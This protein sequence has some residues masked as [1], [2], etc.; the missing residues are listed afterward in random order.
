MLSKR[1]AEARF[2]ELTDALVITRDS[3]AM[4]QAQIRFARVQ[5][6]RGERVDFSVT[7]GDKTIYT[8]LAGHSGR[9]YELLEYL[10]MH[11][12]LL[13]VD[14][15]SAIREV[16]TEYPVVPQNAEGYPYVVP[17]NRLF[18]V[19]P[20]RRKSGLAAIFGWVRGLPI[21]LLTGK[22]PFS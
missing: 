11:M 1:Q 15:S 6:A 2:K 19:P 4:F 14:T 7:I 8:V 21:W 12:S 3:L 9:G 20:K 10:A 5:L 17:L 22:R 13:S 16:Q 18:L